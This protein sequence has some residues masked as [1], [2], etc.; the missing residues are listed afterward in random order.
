MDKREW[1]AHTHTHSQTHREKTTTMFPCFHIY[2]PNQTDTEMI[3]PH[4]CH[5]SRDLSFLVV[6]V[7]CCR[8][9]IEADNCHSLHIPRYA[10]AY[11]V[12]LEA[13]ETKYLVLL[14]AGDK[15][16]SGMSAYRAAKHMNQLHEVLIHTFTDKQ[17]D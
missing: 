17:T 1:T 6:L 5:R 14:Q 13:G 3:Q 15:K 9:V 12:I 2:I 16:G 11:F 7:A 8:F 4:V 10:V